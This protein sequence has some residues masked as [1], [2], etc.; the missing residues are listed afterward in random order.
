[1]SG[2]TLEGFHKAGRT[3]YCGR[4]SGGLGR[5]FSVLGLA[6]S[7]YYPKKSAQVGLGLSRIGFDKNRLR[8]KWATFLAV[9]KRADFV[10]F[11]DQNGEVE[12]RL[13]ISKVPDTSFRYRENSKYEL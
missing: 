5:F 2:Q 9:P 12:I 10:S 4:G 6:G 11:F 13:S 7:I 1:M 3:K 8:P